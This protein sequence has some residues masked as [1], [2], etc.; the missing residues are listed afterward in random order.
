[1]D[2]QL[3]KYLK[4]LKP[5]ID[6]H[7]RWIC[8]ENPKTGTKS[9]LKVLDETQMHYSRGWRNWRR[10]W[11][12][13]ILPKIDD[14]VMFTFVRNPWDKIVSVYHYL[15][16]RGNYRI[17]KQGNSGMDLDFKSFVKL[18]L[19]TGKSL[20]DKYDLTREQA[21]TFLYRD[22]IIP[23][24]YIGRFERLKRDWEI[25]AKRIGIVDRLPIINQTQHD[26][27]TTYYDDECIE[28]IAKRYDKEIKILGYTYG[29]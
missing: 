27:Y 8:F 13:I 3:I 25:L 26:H 15:K 24:I 5:N 17:R 11:D 23:A 1:M 2:K 7:G 12:Y 20:G 19:S 14:I 16:K 10:V 4:Y 22:E 9:I 28:I 29:N 6:I 18:Y 21:S